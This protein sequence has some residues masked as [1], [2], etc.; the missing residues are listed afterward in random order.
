MWKRLSI[1][2]SA[3]FFSMCKMSIVF[4]MVLYVC[5]MSRMRCEYLEFGLLDRIACMCSL[6]PVLKFLSVCTLYLS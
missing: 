4:S 3:P 5:C 2:I 1:F 6:Y